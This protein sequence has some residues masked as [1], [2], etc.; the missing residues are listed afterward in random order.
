MHDL[1]RVVA[2]KSRPAVFTATSFEL[3]SLALIR[4]HQPA[5]RTERPES[6]TPAADLRSEW[7]DP[8]AYRHHG[9]VQNVGPCH[10]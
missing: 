1:S 3:K 4:R 7:K 6:F 8:I 5:H 9:R 10:G 2:P